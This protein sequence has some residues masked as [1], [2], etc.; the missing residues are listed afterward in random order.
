MQVKNHTFVVTGGASGLGA[1]T[2]KALS[3]QGAQ[4]LIADIQDQAGQALATE[5]GQHYVHCD[6]SNPS[7]AQKVIDAACELGSFYGLINCAGIAPAARTISKEAAHD[8]ELFHHTIQVN[9][10]GTFNMNRLAAFAMSKNEALATTE[11]G[12]LINTASIAAYEG[13]IGQIA[14]AASK[15]GIVSMTLPMARDLAGLGIRCVTIAP[16]I[17]ATPMMTSF[18]QDVQDAL[19]ASIP[20]PS[21]LGSAQRLR[22]IGAQHH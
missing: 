6:V 19:A 8:F 2:V 12:V 7:D 17:F 11:R 1:G 4:V 14:Y 10:L 21:R 3:Q 22:E 18:P 15:G 20:F 9:L 16:G 13:Q 5:L